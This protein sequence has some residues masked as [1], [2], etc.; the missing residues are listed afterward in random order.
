MSKLNIITIEYDSTHFY[1]LANSRPRLLIDVGMP[2]TLGEFQHHCK[3]A[4]VALSDIDYLLCTHYHPDHAGIAQDVKQLGPKL[5]VCESQV[6]AI[7]ALSDIVKDDPPYTEIDPS[8]NVV[9]SRDESRALLAT[10][11]IQGE[12]V[13]TPGHSDDSVTLVLDSGEAFTGDLTHP[14]LLWAD[15]TGV[16]RQSW[17]KLR[18]MNVTTVYQAHGPIPQQ[19]AHIFPED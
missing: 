5:I 7:P 6:D 9:I 18:V 3:R 14:M 8:D 17:E 13:E 12:I 1:I 11:G 16:L 4:D 19:M 15:E 10:I 2:G